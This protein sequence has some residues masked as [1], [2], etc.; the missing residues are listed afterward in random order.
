MKNPGLL[1]TLALLVFGCG[2]S[3]GNFRGPAADLNQASHELPV[4][5]PSK[6]ATTGP[7]AGQGSE[8]SGMAGRLV[9]RAIDR[10]QA[11]A[12]DGGGYFIGLKADPLESPI[13]YP[14]RLFGRQILLSPRTTFWA[15][16]RRPGKERP[17]D[18]TE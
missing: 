8:Q 11:S 13:G 16:R 9:L 15:S 1:L 4:G 3:V 2:G 14:L 7:L 5:V 18:D 17:S 10:V 12:P 6:G